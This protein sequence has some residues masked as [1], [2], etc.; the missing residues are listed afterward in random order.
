MRIA[1]GAATRDVIG[2]VLK[3]QM[4]PVAIASVVGLTVGLAVARILSSV[5]F[6]VSSADAVA[7]FAT[8]LV[9]GGVALAA[10]LLPARR[11]S[12]VDPNTVLHCE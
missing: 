1:L 11:A 6:G 3:Q 5:L 4:R 9:V 2:L 7:L 8:L 10:A 12:R